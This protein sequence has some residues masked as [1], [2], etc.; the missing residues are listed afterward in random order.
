MFCVN[1]NVRR[2]SLCDLCTKNSCAQYKQYNVMLLCDMRKNF[3]VKYYKCQ[4]QN[5]N[6][7]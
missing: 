6:N 4:L 5:I 2:T 7:I 3:C 1:T